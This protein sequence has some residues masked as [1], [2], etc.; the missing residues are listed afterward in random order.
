VAISCEDFSAPLGDG[1][2]EYTRSDVKILIVIF[3]RGAGAALH[4]D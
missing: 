4:N 1:V 2:R 3:W